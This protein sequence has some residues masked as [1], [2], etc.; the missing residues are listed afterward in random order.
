[1]YLKIA[2]TNL[3]N[4]R[5][6]YLPYVIASIGIIMTFYIIYSIA[7]NEGIGQMRGGEY[8]KIMMGLGTVIVSIFAVIFLIYTNSFL[9]KQRKKEIGLYSILGMEKKHI[10]KVL[11]YETLITSLCSLG[12]GLL[13]GIIFSKFMFLLLLNI[14]RADIYL[15]FYISIKGIKLTSILFGSVFLVTL[16][17][18]LYHIKIS[19]PINLLHGGE[20]GEREPKAKIFITLFGF[21]T[22]T[23]GYIIALTVKSPISAVFMFFVAAAL[24]IFGVYSL[25]TSGSIAILKMLKKNKSF[26]YNSNNFISVSSMIYRMKANAVGLSNICILSTMVLVVLSIT[27]SLYAGVEN[28]TANLFPMDCTISKHDASEEVESEINSVIK[29]FNINYNIS[30]TDEISYRYIG[31]NAYTRENNFITEQVKGKTGRDNLCNFYVTTVSEF[32]KMKNTNYTVSKGEILIFKNKGNFGFKECNIGNLSFNV[33]DELND[34]Y[35]HRK[36]SNPAMITFGIVV[37]DE[38]VMKDIFLEF[39]KTHEMKTDYS[40]SFNVKGNEAD[41]SG[42]NKVLDNELTKIGVHLSS[43]LLQ[44]EELNSIDGGFLFIGMFLG[45]LFIMATVLIIY[46]KQ[47]S[48]GYDDNLRFK[49]MQKVGMSKFEVKKAIDKQILMVFF[50]PLAGAII[51]LCFAFKMITKLLGALG[52]TNIPLFIICTIVIVLLFTGF[53]IFVF[54]KTAKTYYKIVN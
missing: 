48:E 16:F 25:F 18:N 27:V 20:K 7:M 39:D 2:Y 53:Y 35:I 12:L 29:N 41:V 1:M 14:L 19:N 28:I 54:N 44:K 46:Y 24:V 34:F 38:S 47:I 37:L 8:V 32:N 52:L 42:F 11:L 9:I 45:T 3:K 30:I 43:K 6:A 31:F 51:N 33:R 22:L 4:N 10:G 26:Y 13:L 21:V 50:I 23:S 36:S 49:I 17:S 15:S 5:R 40:L